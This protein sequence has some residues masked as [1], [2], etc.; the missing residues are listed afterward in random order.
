MCVCCD[1]YVRFCLRGDDF[2]LKGNE[3]AVWKK[4]KYIAVMKQ[5]YMV[6]LWLLL[7]TH[8]YR[9]NGHMQQRTY[10]TIAVCFDTECN[11]FSI[12]NNIAT[13]YVCP[14]FLQSLTR[15]MT[16][17][18]VR[19]SWHIQ[20]FWNQEG[21]SLDTYHCTGPYK[22]KNWRYFLAVTVSVT[23]SKRQKIIHPLACAVI[24]HTGNMGL[25]LAFICRK[26]Q[27]DENP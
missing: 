20:V 2:I 15:D 7:D 3:K 27:R 5:I 26:S 25:C 24:V 13:V 22:K 16:R 4:P 19:N 23:E 9:N 11:L 10:A 14:L 21:T 6:V 8:M 12:P 18:R 17:K 1:L